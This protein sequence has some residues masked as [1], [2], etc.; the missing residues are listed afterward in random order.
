[1]S[2]FKVWIN[3]ENVTANTTATFL[4]DSS[5][6][7][8][9]LSGFQGGHAASA[10]FVNT[11]LRQANL[12]TTALMELA[13]GNDTELNYSSSVS[14]V[15]DAISDYLTNE[16][17]VSNAT[18]A[19]NAANAIKV[20]NQELTFKGSNQSNYH[21]SIRPHDGV[22]NENNII[23][24][25]EICTFDNNFLYNVE[26]TLKQG[27]ISAGDILFIDFQ[28]EYIPSQFARVRADGTINLHNMYT[29]GQ[30]SNPVT[31]AINSYSVKLVLVKPATSSVMFD[32][33]KFTEPKC[34]TWTKINDT[35]T[36]DSFTP[37]MLKP[38]KI[39]RIRGLQ[40]LN[41][42]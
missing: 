24:S 40:G 28:N 9:R 17:T 15:K 26:Y 7:N 13:V 25:E 33:I 11:A 16:L 18:N 5:A 32:A 19:T 38:R 1:M 20:N 36:E 37:V 10:K 14:D 27:S 39:Y 3:D 2:S 31:F 29:S 4:N 21:Y 8:E 30:L 23:T 6:D 35:W 12:V 34:A 22:M 42:S 41:L